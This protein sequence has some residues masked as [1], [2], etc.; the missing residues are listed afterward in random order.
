MFTRF[1]S[2]SWILSDDSESCETLLEAPFATHRFPWRPKAVAFGPCDWQKIPFKWRLRSQEW[3]RNT[4]KTM[5]NL[6]FWEVKTVKTCWFSLWSILKTYIETNPH[7]W[8]DS[9]YSNFGTNFNRIVSCGLLL[10]I[11]FDAVPLR[12]HQA[13]F[14]ASRVLGQLRAVRN[15]AEPSRNGVPWSGPSGKL[16]WLLKMAIYSGFSH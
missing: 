16:S 5:E 6:N 13:K 7:A 11:M 15:I 8:N 10:Q 1:R 3:L 2:L 4:R 12:C 14:C 9:C